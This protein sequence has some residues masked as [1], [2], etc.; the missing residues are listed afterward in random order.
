MP[1]ALWS[2]LVASFDI[3]PAGG[4]VSRHQHGCDIGT[5]LAATGERTKDPLSYKVSFR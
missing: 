1:W 2:D 5:E 4:L 3:S